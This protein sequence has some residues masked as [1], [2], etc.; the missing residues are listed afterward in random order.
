MSVFLG[1]LPDRCYVSFWEGKDG[2]VSWILL[3][4]SPTTIF[5][6]LVY[7]PP[8]FN[9]KGLS[10]SKKKHHSKCW[11]TFGKFCFFPKWTSPLVDTIHIY[12]YN[13]IHVPG[14]SKGCQMVLRGVSFH[15]PL[16]F[17]WHPLEGAG[18]YIHTFFQMQYDTLLKVTARTYGLPF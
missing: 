8:F 14:P 2:A 1:T 13:N 7:E 9:S 6:R 4:G 11:L 17:I 5:Y 18:I 10:S 16:G 3:P 15:H 12:I